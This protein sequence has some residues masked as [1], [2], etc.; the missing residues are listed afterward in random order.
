MSGRWYYIDIVAK[1]AIWM[2]EKYFKKNHCFV[3][4][5]LLF[6]VLSF[7]YLCC[8]F[9]SYWFG[10]EHFPQMS[11]RREKK[12]HIHTCSCI[13][14][15]DYMMGKTPTLK[16]IKGNSVSSIKR[17]LIRI[18]VERKRESFT[19]SQTPIYRL[20]FNSNPNH[21]QFLKVGWLSYN[22]AHTAT[23]PKTKWIEWTQKK[24][25]L[26]FRVTNSLNKKKRRWKQKPQKL[27]WRLFLY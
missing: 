1:S 8:C 7:F 10:S 19:A 26:F 18:H 6:F 21:Q 4:L 3:L 13:L 24:T 22:R 15:T 25:L 16:V 20:I 11:K 5:L 17:Y 23:T 9:W 14:L 27:N 2:N 12:T